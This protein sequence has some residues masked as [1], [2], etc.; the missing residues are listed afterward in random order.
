MSTVEIGTNTYFTYATRDEAD[1]YLLPTS[2]NATWSALQPDEQS[3]FLVE[4]ARIIDRQKWKADYDTQEKREVV[5][6][7]VNG[8]ILIAAMLASGEADFVAKAT[9]ASSTKRLK[10]GSAEVEYFRDFSQSSQNRFPVSLME[11]FGVYLGTNGSAS[12]PVGGSFVS[13]VSGC[14]LAS[15][16]WGYSLGI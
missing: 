2:Y 1:A 10:A 8:S 7:I 3:G 6:G 15:Q 13:G 5:E 9:T 14:S 12:A 11:L 4:S 16:P